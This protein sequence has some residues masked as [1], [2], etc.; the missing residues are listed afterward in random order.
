MTLRHIG[1]QRTVHEVIALLH[2]ELESGSWPIGSRIPSEGELASRLGVSRPSIRE[3]VS[4]LVHTGMLAP[5]R[6]KGTYV[7]STCSPV[8]MLREIELASVRDV[9]EI[10]LC[11]DVQVAHFAAQRRTERDLTRLWELLRERRQAAADETGNLARRDA[12][13]HLA[14][15]GAAHNAALTESYRFFA[16]RLQQSLDLFT[17][18]DIQPTYRAQPHE[19]LVQAIQD[20]RPEDAS[21]AARQIARASLDALDGLLARHNARS[22]RRQR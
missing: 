16:G 11:F 1:K 15:V 7:R 6:G 5:Q 19:T 12:S 21:A 13:M 9:F 10:Q 18:Q 22:T 4:A 3:A 8:P 2:D 20:G 14:V 17:R